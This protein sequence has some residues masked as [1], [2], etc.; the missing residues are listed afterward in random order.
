M[1]KIDYVMNRMKGFGIL[2]RVDG[3]NQKV[4]KIKPPF[5]SIKE[6]VKRRRR[7]RIY[8]QKILAEEV[9]KTD[10]HHTFT[11]NKHLLTQLL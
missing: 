1:Q 10:E 7:R 6:N 4:I 8:I 11:L 5:R 2:M 9:M 3:P